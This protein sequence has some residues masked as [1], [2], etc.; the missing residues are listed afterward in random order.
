MLV[1]ATSVAAFSQS[2]SFGST[3]AASGGEMVI[4]GQHSFQNGSGTINAG[5]IATERSAPTGL[6]SW[7]S[8]GSWI[9]AANTAFVDGYARTYGSGAFTFPIGDNNVYRPA[10]V[11][12][13]SNSNPA[14]AAYYGV[15]PSTA[16][17]SNVAGGNHPALPNGGPFSTASKASTVNAVDNVEYW[18]IDGAT[19]ATITLTW[20]AAS[21]IATLTNNNLNNLTIV[22]WNGSQWVEV[23]STVNATQL[24]QNTSASAFT[25][26]ASSLTAGSITTT[27]AIAP[28]TYT[29]YTLA[30][31]A[32]VIAVAEKGILT[33]AGGVAINYV[34]SNDLVNGQTATLGVA[35]NSTVSQVGVWPTGITLSTTSGAISVASGTAAGTYLVTYQLCDKASTPNC[36]TAVDTVQVNPSAFGIANPSIN[37]STSPNTAQLGQASSSISPYGGTMPY[38]YSG[39]TAAGAASNS[40]TRGGTLAV[41]PTTGAYVYTPPT[42]YTG[43][44]TFFIKVCDAATPT[45]SCQIAVIYATV[46]SPLSVNPAPAYVNTNANTPVSNNASSTM[47]PSGGVAPY[48]YSVANAAGSATTTSV[49]GGSVTVNPST[50]VYTYTPATNFSGADT[51]YIKVC[52]A[53][54]P[55]SCG[56]QM[57][58][59]QVAGS[60]SFSASSSTST[61]S[62]PTST[63]LNGSVQSTMN[64][65]GGTAPYTYSSV[66]AAGSPSTA[67]TKGGTIIVNHTTGAFTY[68]PATGYVGNDTFYTKVCDASTPTPNC[69]TK[70]NVV[71]VGGSTPAFTSNPYP[72]YVY[73]DSGRAVSNNAA[74][75]M[76]P[77]GGTAPYTYSV[78]NGAGT[79]STSSNHSGTVSVNPVT[80][81]YTYT[82]AAGFQGIDTFYIKVCDASTPQNCGTQMFIITVGSGSVSPGGGGGTESKTL[83]DVIAVR[84][85]GNAI[86]ST[87]ETT[88][89]TSN[90]KFVNSGAIV[91]GANNLT[92][93]ALVPATV[94][95]TDAAYV[96]TPGDLVNFTN[97]IEVLA[98]D[99]AKGNTTKAVAFGTKTLGDVYTHTKPI[100]D[101]LKGAELMEVKNITVNGFNLMAY[102]VRQ[103]TGE[104]EYAMNLSAGTASNRSTI[105]L[106]SN[107][108]TNSY[109]ADENL[110][111]FQLWAVSYDMVKSMAADVIAK[112]QANGTIYIPTGVIADLP[113]AYISKGSRKATDLTVTVQN[114]TT[115]TTGYFELKEKANELM[116]DAQI[117][118]RQ[119]P[120]TVAANGQSTVSIPVSDNYE[121]SI[122]VYLNN[123][124]TD[125]VYLADGTWSIDYNKNNTTIQQFNVINE[126]TIN[127]S[128]MNEHRLLR[129]VEVAATTKDYVSIYKTMM[130]GGIEQNVAAY[131]SL[132]FNANTIG[133]G[134]VKITLIKKSITNW[135]DQYSYTANI[136]DSKDFA[137]ALNSFKS[138]KFNTAINA[139]DITAINFSFITSRN[140]ATNMTVNLSKVRF[141]TA[142]VAT[143]ASETLNVMSIYP[144]PTMGRFTTTFKSDAVQPLVL[145]VIDVVTGRVVKTQFIN[146]TKSENKINVAIDNSQAITNGLYI[147]TLEGDDIKYIPVKLIIAKP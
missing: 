72:A 1:L 118:T 133:A 129:N 56:Q 60:A 7:A 45:P 52:D 120:F 51:F 8:G 134:S 147:V 61:F 89:Y 90:N 94:A 29:V 68:T 25:G 104:T 11:S 10:A 102:K 20:N 53:A 105:S 122:Y 27:S 113:K 121:G 135:N 144:N 103:R 58:I 28:S 130:G 36:A 112:L 54:T 100:C 143:P 137:I 125:L 86:N 74:S 80:G 55:S 4:F 126:S 114:N 48:T 16:I 77:N 66:N 131:N 136:A 132:L 44:D 21:A 101:R 65:S 40:S 91:N 145:K 128:S 124:L 109:T 79:T 15:N 59:V 139:N 71:T 116:D 83:G 93:S 111:N 75:T 115:N 142:I 127:Q 23:P 117:T 141:S 69:I 37:I 87:T 17:T 18:D 106:Q 32:S 110:Y 38:T 97:A 98:V 31:K 49:K 39:S 67:S 35:G 43:K 73:T 47:S 24:L 123:K 63:P 62:T 76:S 50:G 9:N 30:S 96:S 14:T 41:S 70:M 26:A 6:F 85:Y 46:G 5:I 81:V 22:G 107:W 33:S 64:P 99:Y 34:G 119:V 92:L 2:G 138:S 146:A 13:A 82:P 108:F 78:V 57:F 19:P 84:L 42:N 3:Y 95:N 88:A 140:A 12:A